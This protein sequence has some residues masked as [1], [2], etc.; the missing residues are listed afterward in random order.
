MEHPQM[1]T[2]TTKS[3]TGINKKL[4]SQ[5]LKEITPDVEIVEKEVEQIIRRAER[6]REKQVFWY[7]ARVKK[8]HQRDVM[9]YYE[10]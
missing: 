7:L 6:H 1:P 2:I 9:H 8:P 4:L 3:K 5:L 10:G